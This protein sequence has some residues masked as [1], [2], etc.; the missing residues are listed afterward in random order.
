MACSSTASVGELA[1]V[2]VRPLSRSFEE[3]PLL[4]AR[5]Q[6][7][8]RYRP[9]RD[10]VQLQPRR[11]PR[12]LRSKHLSRLL[13]VAAPTVE[14]AELRARRPVAERQEVVAPGAMPAREDAHEAPLRL[15]LLAKDALLP[16]A[17]QR[18]PVVGSVHVGHWP[19]CNG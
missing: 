7:E 18:I 1:Y 8:E 13:H 6:L 9:E 17:G 5:G 4:A 3:R 15:L 16:A 2:R 11:R 12:G 19:L 14:R 10:H